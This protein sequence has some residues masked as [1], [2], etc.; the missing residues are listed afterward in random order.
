[1]KFRKSKRFQKSFD[2]L[3]TGTQKKARKA[4]SL[5]KNQP[6]H[7]FHPSLVIKKIKGKDGIWEG[8]VDYFYRFT[9]EII[10]EEDEAIY[11][12]RNIGP[13]DI[14]STAP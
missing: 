13:H 9:F 1:M 14:T 11:Y 6:H 10:K 12:F 2:K 5:L 3:P 4:L 8:R 7:P